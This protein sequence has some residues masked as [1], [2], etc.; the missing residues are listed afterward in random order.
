MNVFDCHVN[1]SP[2]RGK[3]EDIFESKEWKEFVDTLVKKPQNAAKI[4]WYFCGR[5]MNS[6]SR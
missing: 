1:R 2:V 3:I 4:C 5:K 6:Y